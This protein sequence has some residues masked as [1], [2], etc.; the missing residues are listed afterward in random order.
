MK[1]NIKFAYALAYVLKRDYKAIIADIGEV[2]NNF[3]IDFDSEKKIS[4][5]DFKQLE[6]VAF[7][8]LYDKNNKVEVKTKKVA[9]V[10]AC[11]CLKKNRYLAHWIKQ[12]STKTVKMIKINDDFAFINK[13]E[14]TKNLN[15]NE[16]KS[17]KLSNMSGNYWLSN[18][19]NKQLQ[20]VT[21]YAFSDKDELKA[22]EAE[23]KDRAER[24]HRKLGAELELFTF[25]DLAGQGHPIWLPNGTAV[26]NVIDDTVRA[27]LV[28][29]GFKFVSTPVLGS[30]E[31]YKT[32][33]HW[34]HYRENMY[35]P[36]KIDNEEMVLRP[37]TCP[38]HMLVYKSKPR[39][40]RELPF[41]VAEKAILHRYEASGALIG[42]ERVRNMQL[43]DTHKIIRPD[44]IESE[45]RHYYQV[46]MEI[47][48]VF[49]IKIH[50][51]DLSLHDPKDKEKYFDNPKMWAK[52]EKELE[53]VMKD[54]GM[55]YE[56]KVGEAA[57]YG[58]KIDIQMKTAL[59][60]IITMSTIQLDFLL[61]ERFKLE[62]INAKGEKER[63]IL[64]HGGIIGTLER[65]MSILLESTKGVFPLWLAP[66]QVQLIPVV[67]KHEP[68]CRKIQA[69]LLD[70]G[71]RAEVD[72]TDE[73]LAKKIRNAQIKKIPYQLV[74]G[75]EEIKSGGISYREYGKQDVT[76]VK[77]VAEFIKLLNKK[78]A[79]RK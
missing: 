54:M 15:F 47:L 74:I 58:P 35:N 16:V 22:Y 5:A 72:N 9:D 8:F 78:I 20:R 1:L 23:L 2:E 4:V 18:A 65:F 64:I 48:K 62:F 66:I 38:H 33:G 24:D 12:V 42:L 3:Y 45:I 49:N 44:Q 59:G 40:Y 60:H 77:S 14:D 21:G 53:A 50:R 70:A 25:D 27:H 52:A 73:R 32:S 37:M 10:L 31:L 30:V 55:K 67:D 17:F 11:S 68:F 63:P 75:D 46:I 29:N 7:N 79:E 56:K 43:I 6:K 19:K 57:F 41:V 69:Q 36:L 51:I 34:F 39:S 28:R 26:M 71:I 61:P 76:K 13:L